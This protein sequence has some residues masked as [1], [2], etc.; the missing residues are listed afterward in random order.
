MH[1]AKAKSV[2]AK[3]ARRASQRERERGIDLKLGYGGNLRPMMTEH[4][5][6][7]EGCYIT[8]YAGSRGEFLAAGIP[9]HLVPGDGSVEFEIRHWRDGLLRATLSNTGVDQWELEID[10][11]DVMPYDA[12]H[13]AICELAR[14]IRID[15]GY[16]F[17]NHGGEARD[18]LEQP[19]QEL[20][21]DDR[22]TDFKRHHKR[23]HP[24]LQ[25]SSDFN[26]R[27][28]EIVE[29]VYMQVHRYGEVFPAPV[30]A[31]QAE[32]KKSPLRLVADNSTETDYG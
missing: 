26:K 11:G 7:S 24:R 29:Q 21:A 25:I 30:Q 31:K 27:L 15:L 28:S 20:I 6:T 22:A 16:W 12:G 17:R 2:P 18:N 4:S 32:P 19:I 3:P 23:G 8:V 14:M 13:P 10:W 9:S 1:M 5:R